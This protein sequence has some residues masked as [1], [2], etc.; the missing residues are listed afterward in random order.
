MVRLTLSAVLCALLLGCSSSDGVSKKDQIIP[1]SDATMKEVFDSKGRPEE[2]TGNQ[3]MQVLR[4]PANQNELALDAYQTN[5]INH[6]PSFR[7]LPNPTLYIYFAPSLS[8]DGGMPIPAW[9]SE[10]KMYDRD[11][12]ALPGEL[13]LGDRQ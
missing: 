3:V 1:P 5:G 7:R 12:Y 9:M 6:K 13:N 10:F 11:Q 2:S 4:R 8:K